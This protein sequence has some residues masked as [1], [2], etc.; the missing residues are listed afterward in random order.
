MPYITNFQIYIKIEKINYFELEDQ[1]TK[2]T[3][4]V[5]RGRSEIVSFGII[6]R[7]SKSITFFKNKPSNDQFVLLHD[8]NWLENLLNRLYSV[9]W[10]LVEN[11]FRPIDAHPKLNIFNIVQL[12]EIYIVLICHVVNSFPSFFLNVIFFCF[13]FYD[14]KD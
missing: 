5:K 1:K 10:S 12:I 3:I 8:H 14:R 11:R 9:W 7:K 4:F 2:P 13:M 6:L